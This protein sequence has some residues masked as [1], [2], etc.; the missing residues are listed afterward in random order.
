LGL[1]LLAACAATPPSEP[2]PPDTWPTIGLRAGIAALSSFETD[3]RLGSDLTPGNGAEIDFEKAL[4]FDNDVDTLRVDLSCR[5]ARH[6]ELDFSYFEIDRR[7][8]GFTIDRDIDWGDTTFPVNTTVNS[9][10]ESQILKLSYRYS[11]YATEEW[12]VATSIGVHGTRLRVGIEG[13]VNGNFRGSQFKQPLPLPVVGLHTTWRFADNLQAKV[14]AESFYIDLEDEKVVRDID[15]EGFILDALAAVEWKF[16]NPL[17][18][19]VGYNLFYLRGDYGDDAL[20]LDGRYTYQGLLVYGI[21]E[22]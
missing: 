8:D 7:S 1:L 4:G 12:D 15:L 13:Q 19:G 17:G 16:G 11:V 3:L 10:F 21:L 14:S 6:H 20:H 9:V 2:A 18:I 22:F 5:L